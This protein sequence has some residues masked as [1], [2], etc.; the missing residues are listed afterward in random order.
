MKTNINQSPLRQY[1]QIPSFWK[2]AQKPYNYDKQPSSVHTADGWR[3]IV[4]PVLDTSTQRIGELIYDEGSDVVTYAVI[5]L[6]EAEIQSRVLSQAQAI[7]EESLQ[8]RIKGQMESELQAITDDS[9]ALEN[10]PAYPLWA[11]LEDG[12]D[13][14]DPFKVQALDGLELKL[15]KIIQP[16]TKQSDR[17]PNVTPALWSKIEFSGGTEVWAQPTGGDG[18]YPLND[19]ATGTNYVVT[20]ADKTWRNIHQGGLNVW[21]PAVFGWEEI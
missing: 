3:E 20:H 12:F 18:K 2:E 21:E 16:H 5:D 9:E 6:T 15:F 4:T 10:A 7:R 14:P 19:P 13:F 17:H 11:D 1:S 8:S